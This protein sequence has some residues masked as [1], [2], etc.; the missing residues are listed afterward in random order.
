MRNIIVT[1]GELFNK[2]AQAMTF[3]AVDEMKR[4]YPDHRIL[5]LSEMDRERPEEEKNRYAFSFI[6]WYPV[7]FAACQSN[8][9][10]RSICQLR[11]REELQEAENIYGNTD[12]MIDISGYGL[13]SNWGLS[14]CNHYLEHL[15]FAKA[16]RIPVYLM[17]QSFGPFDFHG[18][19]GKKMDERI[20][21][22]L[23]STKLICVREQEGYQALKTHY[24]LDNV[25]LAG[26]LVLNNRGIEV[27]NIYRKV[28]KTTVPE[29]VPG[30]TALVPNQRN[31]EMADAHKVHHMYRHIICSLLKCGQNVYLVAHSS[32]D[33]G[34][35]QDLKAAF[36]DEERVKLLDQ[37]FSCLEFNELV[38]RFDFIVGSRFHAI[39]H[40]FKNG[41]PCVALGWAVKYHDLLEQFEQDAYM[42]DV[43]EETNDEQVT[44]IVRRM[45]ERYMFESRIIKRHLEDYQHE[46]V[47]DLIESLG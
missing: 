9:I 7:K 4:R 40:A 28:P 41:I 44:S 8:R 24:H 35:C 17:P 22:L 45:R 12:L 10:L 39:V 27:K 2:G 32:S 14:G 23:A 36:A 1:G 6:G 26:D 25:I 20:G 46:N 19:E 15:E 11:N 33:F 3:I 34:I 43:R 13:G 37:D 30:S 47:F 29:I 38:R 42:I 16:F 18:A 21:A 5:V 31:F